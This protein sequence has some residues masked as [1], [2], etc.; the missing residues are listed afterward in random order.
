MD[1]VI[2]FWGV[3][4]KMCLPGIWAAVAGPLHQMNSVASKQAA[5]TFGAEAD[6]VSPV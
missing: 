1:L 3:W 6:S 4:E 5:K 2:M